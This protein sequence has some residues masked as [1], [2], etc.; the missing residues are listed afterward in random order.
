MTI[1][2]GRSATISV[3]FMMHEG[4][5]GPHDFRINLQTND[6]VEPE[7]ELVILSNWGP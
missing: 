6:P 7:K 4:M 3:Q 2:P 1:A 5:E